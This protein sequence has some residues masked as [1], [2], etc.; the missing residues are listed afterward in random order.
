[1]ETYWLDGHFYPF[2]PVIR[3]IPK[4]L[5]DRYLKSAAACNKYY[6]K[7]GK[8]S[9]GIFLVFCNEHGLLLGYHVLKY[10]EG[11]RTVHNL[12][13]SRWKE[14]VPIIFYDNA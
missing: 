8:K 1:M 2:N 10:S 6:P 11:E 14:C 7:K 4:Y 12:F 9:P 13:Y 5:V 3:D